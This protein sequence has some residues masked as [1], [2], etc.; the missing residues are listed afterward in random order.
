MRKTFGIILFVAGWIVFLVPGVWAW[1][2]GSPSNDAT[3]TT[4]LWPKFF[5]W[6]QAMIAGR[7][8]VRQPKPTE[9]VI[10]IGLVTGLILLALAHGYFYV[11]VALV[12]IEAYALSQLHKCTQ[13]PEASGRQQDSI[14]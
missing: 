1:L 8:L 2:S 7:S 6:V 4:A 10:L 3:L 13:A 9:T 5:V 12:L 11:A 14:L